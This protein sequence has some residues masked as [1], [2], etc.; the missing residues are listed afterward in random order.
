MRLAIAI[1][2]RPEVFA[3]FAPGGGFLVKVVRVLPA[4]VDEISCQVKVALF[5]RL[6]IQLDQRQF[7]F[8]MTRVAAQLALITAEGG[9][10]VVGKA[11][12]GLQQF[13]L[14]GGLRV[15]HRRLNKMAR[16][17]HFVPVAQ[18]C[19]FILRRKHREIGVEV[20]VFLLS[21]RH[22][23]NQRV[24]Q[25]LQVIVRMRR[26]A[27]SHRLQ[28]LAGVGIP[29]HVDGAAPRRDA[30]VAPHRPSGDSARLF[31]LAVDGGD[32]SLAVDLLSLRPK[33]ALDAH[34]IQRHGINPMRHKVISLQ[35]AH[36]RES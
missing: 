24:C 6:P 30:M 32:A 21:P 16:I 22:G 20:T 27:V 17:V 4:L 7:Q 34:T 25:R 1:S 5:A 3:A 13:V 35:S 36:L 26:Q 18:V 12:Q 10:N 15:R 28:P 19:P 2:L 11:R 29:E 23:V 31:Q 33:A 9:V 14:A 8:R